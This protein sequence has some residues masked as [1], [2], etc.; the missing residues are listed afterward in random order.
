MNPDKIFLL[1]S[2]LFIS[3]HIN[4]T[5]AQ[6]LETWECTEQYRSEVLVIAHINEG[7]DTG[8]IEVAGT[9]KNAQFKIDGFDRR[10]DFDPTEDGAFNYAFLIMPNGDGSY[11]DFSS[12]D[13]GQTVTASQFY[14]C[15]LR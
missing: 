12:V 15:R 4:N 11:Y 7:R 1:V 14:I 5:E 2:M 6:I 13:S 3:L 10:W 9:V 8:S